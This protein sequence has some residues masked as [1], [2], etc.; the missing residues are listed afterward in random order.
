VT[1]PIF[2]KIDANGVTA[3]PLYKYL[4]KQKW[5]LFGSSIKWNFTKFLIGRNGE[6]I[7]RYPPALAPEAMEDDIKKLLSTV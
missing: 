4:K 3:D 1:F 7:K 6:V 2:S 5:G